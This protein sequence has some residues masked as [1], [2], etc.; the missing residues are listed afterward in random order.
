VK[1]AAIG[2]QVFDRSNGKMLIEYAKTTVLSHLYLNAIFLPRQARDK[3][4]ENSKKATVFSGTSILMEPWPLS[5]RRKQALS[6]RLS[7][8][9]TYNL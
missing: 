7:T 9:R 2:I 3:P 5:H 4:R 8:G 1:P 6:S